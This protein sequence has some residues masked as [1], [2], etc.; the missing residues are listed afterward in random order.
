[1]RRLLAFAM[2]AAIALVLGRLELHSPRDP[3]PDRSAVRASIRRLGHTAPPAQRTAF[4]D[5]RIDAEEYRVAVIARIECMRS[6]GGSFIDILGPAPIAGG[7]LLSWHYR[8]P[9]DGEEASESDRMCA[10]GLSDA[11]ERGWK[12]EAV[13]QGQA[14]RREVTQL[15]ACL[16]QAGVDLTES[17]VRSVLTAAVSAEVPVGE[18]VDQHAVLFDL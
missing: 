2:G 13:P 4:A 5:D 16:R 18:C 11:I 12:L 9:G 3:L 6:K 10:A 17:D 7:R 8:S 15:A 14:R 1:M